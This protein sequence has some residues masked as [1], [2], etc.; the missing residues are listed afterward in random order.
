MTITVDEIIYNIFV[1]VFVIIVSVLI[2]KIVGKL[3]PEDEEI[4]AEES[5]IED[6]N[7]KKNCK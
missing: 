1:F 6:K 2:T 7:F 5:S 3:K 4:I